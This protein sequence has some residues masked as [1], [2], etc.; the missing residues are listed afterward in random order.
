MAPPAA[1][2]PPSPELSAKMFAVPAMAMAIKFLKIDLAGFVIPLRAAYLAATLVTAASF[3]YLKTVIRR[4]NESRVITVVEKLPGKT[5]T[6]KM[7]TADYDAKECDKKLQSAFVSF[8]VVSFIHYK[9]GSPM[10][11]LLQSVMQLMN[12]ADD[13]MVQIHLMDKPP[14][15]KLQRPFKVNNPLADLFDAN[16][17]QA[18]ND[19]KKKD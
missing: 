2:P 5:E 14:T 1:P 15:G 17:D 9:W 11:L 8:L 16:S 19:T 4:K 18:A 13:P 12:L 3:V 10:P 6:K 7:S